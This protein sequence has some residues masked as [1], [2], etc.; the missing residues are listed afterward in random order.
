[1]SDIIRTALLLGCQTTVTITP[2]GYY[3]EEQQDTPEQP[4]LFQPD[5]G[6]RETDD[7]MELDQDADPDLARP[8]DTMDITVDGTIMT[9]RVAS[10]DM[11]AAW[12]IP[13]TV[14]RERMPFDKDGSNDWTTS[15]LR[16][17]MNG[18]YLDHLPDTIRR[19]ILPY[20]LLLPGGGAD[21]CDVWAPSEEQTFGSAIFGD[22]V[23]PG[24]ERLFP[25]RAGRA[26][27]DTDG[28]ERWWW[29]RSS[30]SGD[31]TVVPIVGSGGTAYSLNADYTYGGALPCF[32]LGRQ[33]E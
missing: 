24:C 29:T 17:W 22:D 2:A 25:D 15:S 18:W 9:Y 8:G 16:A 11:N 28:A 21:I 7:T 6:N 5:T 19:R 32:I 4:V 33:A 12:M 31:T 10:T 3:P 14:W 30:Y 1:M 20:H 13:T 23:K 26:L 27:T